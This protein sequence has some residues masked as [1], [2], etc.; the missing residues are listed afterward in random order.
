HADHDRQQ[1]GQY[2]DGERDARSV[3][4][5]RPDVPPEAV[6][7]ERMEV[8]GMV[9]GEG[10]QKPCGHDVVLCRRTAARDERPGDCG[11][12]HDREHCHAE[13]GP[14]VAPQAPHVSPLPRRMRGS[15]HATPRSASRLPTTTNTA[16]TTAAAMTTGESRARTASTRRR[17]TPVHPNTAPTG[18][19]P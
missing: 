19:A 2:A 14:A 7:A 11:A 17:P 4:Q 12:G 10:P 5:S 9:R 3:D 1:D 6:G 16:V 18:T 8:A 13:G 15:I